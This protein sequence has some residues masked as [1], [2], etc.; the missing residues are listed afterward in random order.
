MN[1]LPVGFKNNYNAYN[2]IQQAN[3]QTKPLYRNELKQDTVCF[4][5]GKKQLEHWTKEISHDVVKKIHDESVPELKDF[6]RLLRDELKPLVESKQNP[7][8]IICPGEVGIKGRVKGPDSLREKILALNSEEDEEGLLKEILTKSDIE[9][10]VG[11]IIGLRIVFRD[12]SQSNFASVFKKFENLVKKGKFRVLEIENYRSNPKNAYVGQATLDHFEETCRSVGLHPSITSK[13]RGSGYEAVHLNVILPDGK[14]AEIQMMG[15][16]IEQVKEI[17]DFFYK[18]DCKKKFAKRYRHIQ[19]LMEE[20]IKG[21]D[22]LQKG[23]LSRYITDSY[24]HAREIPALPHTKREYSLKN[25]IDFP[26]LLPEELSFPHLY[27]MK[28]D[29]DF[30]ATLV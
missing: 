20:K 6:L 27:K 5:S 15:R 9:H 14:I 19:E 12:S 23:V 17:E 4:T 11:D 21:L 25:F 26:Y 7:N 10:R 18:L 3:Y 28:A 13:S 8:G 24:K 2:Q 30:A 1:I 16:D 29:A 22:D